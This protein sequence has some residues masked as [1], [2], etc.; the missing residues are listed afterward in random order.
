MHIGRDR[1][2]SKRE[3]VYFPPPGVEATKEDVA[4]FGVNNNLGY[5]TFT[6]KF[7]YLGS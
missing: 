7:K 3:A 6:K 5:I 4:Q 2:K 1:K